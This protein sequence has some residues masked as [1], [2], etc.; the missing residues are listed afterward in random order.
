MTGVVFFKTLE[1]DRLTSFYTEEVGAVE[2]AVSRTLFENKTELKGIDLR[3]EWGYR[4]LLRGASRY[5]PGGREGARRW[6][7]SWF[8]PFCRAIERSELVHRY[9]DIGPEDIYVIVVR[10]YDDFLGGIPKKRSFETL[11][12]GF[13]FARKI[14]HRP[15]LFRLLFRLFGILVFRGATRKRERTGKKTGSSA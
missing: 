8:L 4:I 11:I 13:L 3:Y 1:L 10:F 14:R 2:E 12:S 7:S 5:P 9:P 15:S 6:F